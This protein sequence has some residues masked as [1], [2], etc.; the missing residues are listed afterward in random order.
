MLQIIQNYRT[1]DISIIDVPIPKPVSKYVLVKNFAS[2]V[3][4]GTEKSMIEL[5]RKSLL[6]K[7]RSRPD[8]LKR[9]LEKAKQEGFLK[10]FREAL[11]RL[12]EPVPLGYS[13]S[14]VVEKVGESVGEF[15]P[16][17]RVAC[18]GA[19]YASHAEYVLVPE[20]LCAKLPKNVSFEE[21]AF[22]MIGAIA[23]HGI[24]CSKLSFGEKA[25]VIGLG[26]LGILTAQILRAYGIDVIGYDV[27]SERVK[28]AEN[29]GFEN[30]FQDLNDFSRAVFNLTSGYGA[31]AVLL[32]LASKESKPIDTAIELV[33]PQGRIV[34]VGVVDIHP[35]RNEMWHK[36]VEIVVSKAAGPGINDP[37]YEIKGIDYPIGSIRWT[38]RRNLEEF[39]RLLSMKL[40]DVKSLITHRVNIEDSESIKQLYNEILTGKI[41]PLGVIINYKHQQ[42]N[43]TLEKPIRTRT[44][45]QSKESHYLNLGVV[46]AGLFGRT[47]LLPNLKKA[48]KEVEGVNLKVVST[49]RG[50]TAAHA[51]RR[52]DFE[53]FTTDFEDI[54]NDESIQAVLILSP[55]SQ[56]KDMV[57]RALEKGKSVFV[58]KPLCVNENEL[59]EIDSV[60]KRIT[61][62]LKRQ[63]I[64][65]VGYNRR[66]SSHVRFVKEFFQNRKSPMMLY[67]RINVGHIPADHWV[68]RE[69]EGGNMIISEVCHFVD[70][71]MYITDS[72]PVRLFAQSIEHVG[73][74][75][76]SRDNVGITMK[77][78]DG[79][80]GNILYTTVGSR[81]YSRENLEIFCDGKVAVI[82][83]FRKT[84]LYG[85]G[86]KKTHKTFS[87]DMGYLEE[88]KQFLTS[89][90]GLTQ[91]PITYEEIYHSTLTIFKI[92]ESIRTN[93]EV[94][95]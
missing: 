21:G 92:L 19:G 15:F 32:T 36:E 11:E 52:F 23:I 69:E 24:R 54:L 46:G 79:S 85:S 45:V 9:F 27:D 28:L 75:V 14:G 66:F 43:R 4:V 80:V 40:I 34:V 22:G 87:Q 39:L 18:I 55:H 33:R 67:Y 93:K 51:A 5:G 89:I 35:D 90:K 7:A 31:D 6:G 57:I 26:L 81:T 30:V 49:A 41:K 10:T 91:I 94:E 62:E 37:L 76:I 25:A 3:S 1:G 47:V 84:S 82:T 72:I 68:H 20:M 59:L 83:D 48:L 12:D 78:A 64:F 60:Y 44:T 8:L 61:K 95:I 53:I 29:L 56:H 42:E 50:F 65:T 17:D 58:E 71:M 63:I 74:A 16:G 13:C 38:E 86:I 2:A 73:K 70:L 88:M 77:F